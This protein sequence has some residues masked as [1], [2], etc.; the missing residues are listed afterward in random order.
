M[1][2]EK[3]LVDRWAAVVSQAELYVVY[4]QTA[5]SGKGWRVSLADPDYTKFKQPR[6]SD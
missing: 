3:Y 2:L 6:R 4:E 1:L 5:I